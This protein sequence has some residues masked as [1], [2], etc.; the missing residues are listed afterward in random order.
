MTR[1]GAI[2]QR[3]VRTGFIESVTFEL[4]PEQSEDAAYGNTWSVA[5]RGKSYSKGPKIGPHPGVCAGWK[6]VGRD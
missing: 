5:G 2:S 3:A 4:R 1:K 6:E